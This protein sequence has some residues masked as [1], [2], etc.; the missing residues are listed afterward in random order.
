MEYAKADS[1][2]AQGSPLLATRVATAHLALNQRG[3]ALAT[4]EASLENYPDFAAS[5]RVRGDILRAL[6]RL[7]DAADAYKESV[8]IYPY[9]MHCQQ[10]LAEV[11]DKLANETLAKKHRRYL[12]LLRR[13]GEG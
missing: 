7:K 13:G 11:Y 5:H 12:M 10:A 9:D 3:D 6:G 2:D 8:A 4:V 1:A